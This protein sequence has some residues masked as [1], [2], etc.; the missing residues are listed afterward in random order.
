MTQLLPKGIRLRS[1]NTLQVQSSKT[2]WVDGK[3]QVN[4]EFED[5]PVVITAKCPTY[6][7][8]LQ[9]AIKEAMKI[10]IGLDTLVA[11]SGYG[12]S[13]IRKAFGVGKLKETFDMLFEKR[14]S[15]QKQEKNVLI[16]ATDIFNYFPN[17]IR[18]D[19]MQTDE[20]YEGFKKFVIKQIEERPMN[21]LSTVSNKSVNH[22]LGIL[23]ETFRYAIKY[24]L[25][26]QDKLLNPDIRAKDMGWTNLS[27]GMSKRKRPLTDEEVQNIYDQ[28]VADGELEFAD[29]F[30]WLV[31][32]G[33]R[34]KTEFDR[35]TVEDIKYKQGHVIFYREKTGGW[36]VP[37][38]LTDRCMEIAKARK[39][40]AFKRNGHKGR[41]FT[42]GYSRRRTLFDR[43]KKRCNLP[44]DFKPYATRHTFITR[45]VEAGNPPNVVK[46]LAGHKCIETTFTF[47]A[48]S[49]DK[50]LKK[51]IT[52]INKPMSMIGHNRRKVD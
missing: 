45:L 28:A 6:D 38:P 14:W 10:K 11:S 22:R 40:L 44:E 1:K 13:K 26:D 49:S 50:A 7:T 35:F 51:A 32:T 33:M 34:H 36:S 37:I 18:L 5:V 39:E 16:Y 31:D 2:V 15:G 47:Y 19:E 29:A 30:I 20:H 46:D 9:S 4:R 21:N 8:A 43:Y 17:D 48:Q 12:K 23:R 27:V 41:L 24:G 52:S 42:I 25:L 3:K